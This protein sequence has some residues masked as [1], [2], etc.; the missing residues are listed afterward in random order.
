MFRHVRIGVFWA[1]VFLVVS[2]VMDGYGKP[3]VAALL[4]FAAGVV[5]S[6]VAQRLR[7]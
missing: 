6:I 7:S 1:L 5:S 3:A 4:G 2:L